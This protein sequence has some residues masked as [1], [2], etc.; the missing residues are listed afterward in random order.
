MLKTTG[1]LACICMAVAVVVGA[2]Y[3]AVERS[4]SSSD[5]G[6]A[7][8]STWGRRGSGAEASASMLMSDVRASGSR[9][10]SRRG[11]RGER[12][13]RDDRGVRGGH[14]ERDGHGAFSPGRGL[15]GVGLTLLQIGAIAGIVVFGQRRVGRR[16]ATSPDTAG[17]GA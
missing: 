17:Q 1:R 4:G 7:P 3:L 9:F 11:R 8:D 14:G 6:R 15:A 16:R 10:E 5:R 12:H 13:D 2:L